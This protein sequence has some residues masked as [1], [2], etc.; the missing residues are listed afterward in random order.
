V[1]VGDGAFD[2]VGVVVDGLA[3]T[4]GLGGLGGDGAVLAEEGG[5]GVA[6]P[7]EDG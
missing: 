7:G 1:R 3:A 5:G 2:L 6:D 4:A